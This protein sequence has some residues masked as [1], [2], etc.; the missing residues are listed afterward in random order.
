MLLR[1]RGVNVA[2]QGGEKNNIISGLLIVS[3]ESWQYSEVGGEIV[4][5]IKW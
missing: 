2:E 1:L 3:Y 5:Q 4:I